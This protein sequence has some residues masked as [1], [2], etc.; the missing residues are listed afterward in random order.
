[1]NNTIETHLKKERILVSAQ[2]YFR[3]VK[4]EATPPGPGL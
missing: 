2:D 1:M 4:G 3:E